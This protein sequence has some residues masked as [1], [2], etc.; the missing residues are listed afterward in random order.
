MVPQNTV[1]GQSNPKENNAGGTT[2]PDLKLHYKAIGIKK[3][4][5]GMKLDR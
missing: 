1:D 5:T 2:I 4:G 3:P